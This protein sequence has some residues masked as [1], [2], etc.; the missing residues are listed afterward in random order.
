MR[1][2]SDLQQWF[3]T[4]RRVLLYKQ[5]TAPVENCDICDIYFDI[6]TFMYILLLA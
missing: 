2:D 5:E 3:W 6:S 1:G 4:S